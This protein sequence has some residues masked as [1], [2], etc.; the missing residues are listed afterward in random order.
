M[1]SKLIVV[2]FTLVA[3]STGFSQSRPSKILPSGNTLVSASL[4][5]NEFRA[6]FRTSLAPISTSTSPEQNFA[7]CTSSRV[8][9]SLTAEIKLFATSREVFVPRSAYADLGDISNAELTTSN[10]LFVLTIRGGDASEA[11]IAKIEF[12]R[13]RVLRRL[14][15]SA[16]DPA[17]PLEVSQYH[18]VSTNN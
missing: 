18:M 16:E 7:Q 12:N 14:L 9:C 11:Y 15:Y 13:E 3:C 17:H 2:S 5:G 10:R 8:P 4:R 6:L 1:K